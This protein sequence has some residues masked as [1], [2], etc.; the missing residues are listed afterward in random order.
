MCDGWVAVAAR[1]R[2]LLSFCQSK[3]K[4]GKVGAA[5]IRC[6]QRVRGNLV[7][8][9]VVSFTVSGASSRSWG[10]LFLFVVVV[11]RR[12]RRERQQRCLLLAIRWEVAVWSRVR[13]TRDD[14]AVCPSP[15]F[16]RPKERRLPSNEK[17]KEARHEKKRSQ[18]VEISVVLLLQTCYLVIPTQPVIPDPPPLYSHLCRLNYGESSLEIGCR[19]RLF[20]GNDGV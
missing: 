3:I 16:P 1:D 7:K 8:L 18:R 17:I 12:H 19:C 5:V 13:V 10:L 20:S 9:R 6:Q 15:R 2:G 14:T 4:E 11:A